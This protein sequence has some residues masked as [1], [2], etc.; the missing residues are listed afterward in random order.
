MRFF[1]LLIGV[2]CLWVPAISQ[3][4]L[5]QWT[6]ADGVMH[7]VDEAAEVPDAYRAGMKVYRAAK[8]TTGVSPLPV[9]PS[10]SYAAQSQGAFAQRIALDLGLVKESSE[11]ALGPL[12]GAGIQPA[13]G[14][15]AND[16]LTLEVVDDVLA[17]ARRAA[18]AKR[19]PLSA[20]GAEAVIRQAGEAFLPPPRP[21]SR[22]G[23]AEGE[24]GPEYGQQPQP[25]IIEQPP[26]QI[27]EV[28][29]APD[30]GDVPFIY[31]F[32]GGHRHH[33]HHPNDYAGSPS[34]PLS[35]HFTPNPADVPGSPTHLPFGASHLPL[36]SRQTR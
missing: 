17:A 33:D 19:L 31:G 2:L 29:G 23:W 18:D 34:P 28:E 27:F 35:G 16:P 6:D 22:P 25:I 20:D 11:D 21:D 7:I 24:D 30:Y 15:E 5:Y 13:S 10:R 8:P 1:L 32:P 4:D 3:A 36:G 26:P 14:W 12:G 9:S